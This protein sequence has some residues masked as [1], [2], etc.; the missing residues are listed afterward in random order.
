MRIQEVMVELLLK[1]P[2]YGYIAASVIPAESR[3]VTSMSMAASNAL[4]LYYNKDWFES[5][6]RNQAVG[7]V[8]HEL[9][10]IVLLHP[11]RKLNREHHLWAISC[12][13]AVNEHIDPEFLTCDAVTVEKIEKEIK[14]PI[15]RLKSA[16]FYY[17]IISENDNMV[18]FIDE[19]KDIRVV[20]K[21]GSQLKVNKSID[22][23]SSEVNKNALKCMVSELVEQAKAEGEIP[24][25]ITEL[26]EDIYGIN[27]INWR[28]ILKRFL[29]G[30]GKTISRKTC[31]KESRR[32]EGMPGNRRSSGA[33]V[34][35]A[36]DESGSISNT[37]L[38][39][40]HK[41]VMAISKITGADI[42]VTQFDTQCTE[43]I[44][45]ERFGRNKERI[46]NGGTD[47]RPVFKLADDLRI[48]LV[49]VFTDGDGTAPDSS[50]QQVLWVLTKNGRKPANYGHSITFTK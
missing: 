49:I 10:H 7:A 12:D 5:L 19:D 13:M 24:Q 38:A 16:E 42:R 47:F 36:I 30:R 25:G 31:K 45:I 1:Q 22:S 33:D 39:G 43:P 23:D 9:L 32:F 6:N 11:F 15:P 17:D 35:L 4:C 41:E 29:W 48:P 40:F 26:L 21:N 20:L 18:S 8:M 27:E 46:K 50:C 2:F 44:P 28:N 14:T 37:D 34:L 3:D